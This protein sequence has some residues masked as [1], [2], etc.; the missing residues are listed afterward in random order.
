[1]FNNFLSGFIGDKGKHFTPFCCPHFLCP[2]NQPFDMCRPTKMK[3]IQRISPRVYQYRCK[4][5]GCL[6]NQGLDGPAVPSDMFSWD[7]NPS[8]VGN[9]P[10]FDFKRW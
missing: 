7:I 6:V 10:N 8:L 3:F 5:C 9:K 4:H 1:M 2:S